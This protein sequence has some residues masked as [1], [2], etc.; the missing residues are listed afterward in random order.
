VRIFDWTDACVAHPFLDLVTY[1]MRSNDMHVRTQL[2][3]RYLGHW[4]E[5]VSKQHLREAGALA[6]LVGALHQ[7]HTYA[8]LIPTVMPDDLGALKGGDASWVRRA[9]RR[10]SLG[11][12]GP[13]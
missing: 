4:S 3:D 7:A 11:L 8:Q 12:E 2:M 9:L 13:Y 5:F 10:K 1:I 6:L